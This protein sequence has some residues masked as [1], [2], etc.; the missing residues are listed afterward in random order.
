MIEALGGTGPDSAR[1][2]RHQYLM[3]KP[4]KEETAQERVAPLYR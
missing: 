1:P 2:P 4:S 3:C